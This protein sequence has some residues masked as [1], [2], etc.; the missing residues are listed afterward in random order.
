[1]KNRIFTTIILTIVFVQIYAQ[2][3]GNQQINP[4]I[5]K[6]E[7]GNSSFEVNFNPGNLFGAD[8]SN[9][10]NLFDGGIK[11][12]KFLTDKSAFRIELNASFS[13]V[14]TISQQE[15]T[16]NSL[17]ELKDKVSTY[18]VIIKPGYEKHFSNLKRFSPYVGFQV[19]I[20][21]KSNLYIKE[22]QNN[23]QQI[24]VEKW[25][26][27]ID[28][29]NDIYGSFGIGSGVFAGFDFYF[30]KKLYLGLEIGYGIEY[31]QILTTK[32]TNEENPN[33]DYERKNGNTFGIS[34]SL[35]TGNLRLGWTF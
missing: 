16:E 22:N 18:G 12:R 26:N 25:R 8:S 14:A 31:E 1:M 35:A 3:I 10:F 15:N 9:Q 17:L 13:R 29:D 11:F 24:Y 21:Y 6:Q 32:Y 20:G 28:S 19:L 2:N 7:K 34:P 33:M 23:K 5:Y 4:S 30:V 27:T